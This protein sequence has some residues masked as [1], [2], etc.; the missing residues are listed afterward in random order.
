MLRIRKVRLSLAGIIVNQLSATSCAD[1][2]VM[3]G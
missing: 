2:G 1:V 3:S